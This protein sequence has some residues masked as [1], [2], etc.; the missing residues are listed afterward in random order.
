MSKTV[1]VFRINFPEVS[2]TFIRAQLGAYKNYRPQIYAK[3]QLADTPWP[4]KAIS[5]YGP[6]AERYFMATRSPRWHLKTSSPSPDLLH[7]HFGVDGVY[8]LP[9]AQRLGIPLITTFHGF[10]ILTR[11]SW[12]LR[13]PSL[14]IVVYLAHLRELQRDGARFI[15]V[16]RFVENALIAAG[17]PP[18]RIVQ[19]YIGVDTE[20]FRPIPAGQKSKG[21]FV[22]SVARHVEL[23]GIDVLLKAFAHVA[24][25]HP[26]VK[27]L[28]VGAG[29][30]TATLKKLAHDLEIGDQVQ[31]LGAQPN[32]KVVE[33]LQ[34]AEVFALPCKT[35]ESG[36]A[37]A[38]GIVFNEASACGIPIVATR[39]GGIPEV[40]EDKE[41][42]F[43]SAEG[44]DVALAENLASL[45]ADP[46]IGRRLGANGR[47]LVRARFDL[48]QQTLKLEEIY[49]DVIK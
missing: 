18:D 27:L 24:R 30:L 31:F 47:E 45:L 40:V 41:T 35:H 33:L 14:P 1:G 9:L 5:A 48:I 23:K 36:R 29:P 7:A 43:L 12:W 38:L 8:A 21:R 25:K 46:S 2:E 13:H 49:D 17:F 42:G 10:D 4:I 16:S 26:D 20:K 28:Q 44:D 22:L 19:H 11:L 15:A 39:S 34:N 37:E 32:A 6:W 3:R